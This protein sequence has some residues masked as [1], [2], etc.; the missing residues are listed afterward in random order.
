VVYAGAAGLVLE[1]TPG[2]RFG[3][4]RA[5]LERLQ[6]GGSTAG[7]QGIRLAYDMARQG[8]IEGGINRV[9]LATDGD[10]NV[11]VSDVRQ[12][13]DMIERER[14]TGVTLTTLGFGQGNYN[15]QLMERLADAGN[16]N[17]AYIDTLK[18]AQKVLVTEMSSTLFT[19]AKDVKIQIEF[20]PA[21][22]AEYRLIGYENRLLDREDFDNDQVDAGDIG[23]GHSV[24]ALYELA[25]VGSE[26][27]RLKPLRYADKADPAQA[28][29]DELGFLRL[30][31]KL[32]DE[33]ESRLIE[34][35]LERADITERPQDASQRLRFAAAVAGFGQILRGGKYTGDYT[36]EN[37]LELAGR[38]RGED[39]FGYRGEFLSLV[40]LAAGLT[41]QKPA[42]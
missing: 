8:F 32:P 30:R 13:E 33:D 4:I 34:T 41:P 37:V 28:R 29:A 9:I 35:P 16:G 5:A 15:D 11:G 25:L 17:H 36:Y 3:T 39:R 24:T 6:A 20:N 19:I 40:R 22:V 21:V 31:Y 38:A 18:E 10:F 7:G 2:D 27:T 12:L 1:P 26:G 23:A 14:E 42:Q